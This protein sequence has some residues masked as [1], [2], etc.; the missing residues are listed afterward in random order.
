MENLILEFNPL[1][2]SLA[3]YYNECCDGKLSPEGKAFYA[4]MEAYI[5]HESVD[6]NSAKKLTELMGII[7]MAITS[8]LTNKNNKFHCLMLMKLI[9]LLDADIRKVFIRHIKEDHLKILLKVHFS[10]TK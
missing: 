7:I 5:N 9:E 4:A 3:D 8:T 2:T 1:K 6:P 10:A